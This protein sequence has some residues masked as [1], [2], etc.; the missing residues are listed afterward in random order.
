MKH[1]KLFTYSSLI[2]LFTATVVSAQQQ[3]PTLLGTVKDASG[4][5]VPGAA[6]T[7][8]SE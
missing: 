7:L 4:A 8:T 3:N 5:V 6:L 1:G 2:C